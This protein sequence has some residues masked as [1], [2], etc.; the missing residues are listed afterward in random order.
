LVVPEPPGV[1]DPVELTAVPVPGRLV[2]VRL[3]AFEMPY[4]ARAVSD[5]FAEILTVAVPPAA[6]HE[7][8]AVTVGAV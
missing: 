6:R 8:V 5:I 7:T 2:Y 1:T 4:P 3:A